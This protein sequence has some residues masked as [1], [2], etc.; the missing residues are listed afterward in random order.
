[1]IDAPGASHEIKHRPTEIRLKKEDKTL[2]LDFAGGERFSLSAEFL[3]VSSPSAEVRGHGPGQETLI[4]GRRHVGIMDIE[5]VGNYAIRILFD[6]LHDTGIY[7][8]D[9]LYNFGRDRDRLWRDY[10]DRL[11]AAGASREP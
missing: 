1:M 2:E 8:W 3:R 10:L 6:D 4:S 5:A 7:S 11:D 9:L